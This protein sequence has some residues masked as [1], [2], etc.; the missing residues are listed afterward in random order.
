MTVTVF[1]YVI[2]TI[3]LLGMIESPNIYSFL[4]VVFT[5]LTIFLLCKHKIKYF[6]KFI[7]GK[8]K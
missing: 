7:L 1:Q 6:I 3:S 5:L 2:L 4:C 8:H